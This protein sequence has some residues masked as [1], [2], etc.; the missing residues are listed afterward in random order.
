MM[1]RRKATT[2]ADLM[3]RLQSDPEW[4]RRNA[5]REEKERARIAQRLAEIGPEHVPLVAELAAAGVKVRMNPKIQLTLPPEKRPGQA[6]VPVT[7]VSDLVNSPDSYPEAV[8]ILIKH[9]RLVR[10]PI[11]INSLARALTVKEARG[12]DAPLAVLDRL[13][14]TSPGMTRAGDEFQARWA[15]ANAL[16]VIADKSMTAELEELLAD[17]RYEDV[18]ECLET[19]MKNLRAIVKSR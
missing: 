11:M 1:S 6:P 10:H 13:K 7:S 16:T 14:Q 18:K 2:A 15:L 8:P 19:A 12:T 5:E 17:A 4:V 3:A 9:L